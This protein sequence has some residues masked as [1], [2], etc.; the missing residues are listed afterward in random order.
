MVLNTD[1]VPSG[2]EHSIDKFNEEVQQP[3]RPS[4]EGGSNAGTLP[5]PPNGPANSSASEAP[6]QGPEYVPPS[7]DAEPVFKTDEEIQFGPSNT[8]QPA[9]DQPAKYSAE[10]KDKMVRYYLDLE[11]NGTAWLAAAICGADDIS[12]F[13]YSEKQKEYLL[14]ALEPYKDFIISALP[15]WLPLALVYF[16]MKTDQVN[17][18]R[19][20]LKS[21]KNNATGKK[22]ATV[23]AKLGSAIDTTQERK[24]FV[25]YVDG[26]YRH[27]RAGNYIK[28]RQGDGARKLEKPNIADLDKILAVKNNN[29]A[30]LLCAAFDITEADFQRMGIVLNK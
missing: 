14:I 28:D 29:F 30:D 26:Y 27:D 19:K 15:E 10:Y 1:N 16:G 11:E 3:S 13:K 4:L 5:P 17:T 12:M 8:L 18:G 23:M 25:L 7:S 6:N 2:A 9:T 21:K 22:D 24:N 20:L